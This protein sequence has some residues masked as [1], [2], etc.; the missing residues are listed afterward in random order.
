MFGYDVAK[1]RCMELDMVLLSGSPAKTRLS[2]LERQECFQEDKMEHDQ[3]GK[4][5]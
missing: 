4:F 3:H 1:R 2:H 5:R